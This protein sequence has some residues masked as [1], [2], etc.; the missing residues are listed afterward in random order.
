MTDE[1]DY[2]D[3]VRGCTKRCPAAFRSLYQRDAKN[4]IRA[5]QRV[6]R[7]RSSAEDI[8]HDVFTKLWGTPSTYDAGRGPAKAWLWTIVRNRAL[9][10]LRDRGRLADLA[11]AR[12]EQTPDVADGPSSALAKAEDEAA[13]RRGIRTLD[14]TTR[15]MLSLAYVEERSQ[16][17]IAAEFEIPLNTAKSKV[18]RGLSRLRAAIG[19]N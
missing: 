17:E 11:E 13:L 12:L 10:V 1:F 15:Q 3:A 7:C 19:S 5:A 8:V 16:S 9:N 6:V 14:E 2:E 4:L 18:R